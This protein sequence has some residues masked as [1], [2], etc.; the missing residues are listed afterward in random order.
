MTFSHR[1]GQLCIVTCA[2]KMS[3]LHL[4]AVAKTPIANEVRARAFDLIVL[5]HLIV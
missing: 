4:M 1:L 5:S 2:I 3:A